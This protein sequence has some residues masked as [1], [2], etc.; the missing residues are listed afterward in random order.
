MEF[1]PLDYPLSSFFLSSP[2]K[3]PI[4]LRIKELRQIDA[5]TQK[6]PKNPHRAKN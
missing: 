6:P 2:L 5:S 1:R 3:S 4:T